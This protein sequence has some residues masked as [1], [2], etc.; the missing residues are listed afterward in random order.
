MRQVE[1]LLAPL[2]QALAAD[3]ATL[4]FLGVEGQEL[5]LSLSTAGAQCAECIVPD[6][7]IESMLLKQLAGVEDPRLA[8][9]ERVHIAHA[10]AA[11]QQ[12]QPQ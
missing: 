5:R 4:D 6:A 9:I 7:I 3:G 1:T 11:A 12:V 10:D 2:Q 8:A